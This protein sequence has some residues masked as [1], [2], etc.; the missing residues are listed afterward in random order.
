MFRIYEQTKV[1][2]QKGYFSDPFLIVDDKGVLTIDNKNKQNIALN[3]PYTKTLNSKLTTADA[4]DKMFTD[5]IK[6]L[7]AFFRYDN[8]MLED[9]TVDL[10]SPTMIGGTSWTGFSLSASN[11]HYVET[12]VSTDGTN[13]VSLGEVGNGENRQDEYLNTFKGTLARY[14]RFRAKRNDPYPISVYEGEVYLGQLYKGYRESIHDISSAGVYKGSYA[15]WNQFLPLGTNAWVQTSISLDSGSTWGSWHDLELLGSI[16]GV[17]IGTDLSNAKL[18]VRTYIETTNINTPRFS[19]FNLY[20]DNDHSLDDGYIVIPNQKLTDITIHPIMTSNTTPSPYV[21]TASG[22]V[23]ETNNPIYYAFDGDATNVNTT[24]WRVQGHGSWVKIDLGEDNNKPIAGYEYYRGGIYY[25]IDASLEGSTDDINWVTLSREPNM[26]NITKFSKR[27]DLETNKLPYRYYKLVFN[28]YNTP[29]GDSMY[30]I[31][32]LLAGE[33]YGYQVAGSINVRSNSDIRS[34]MTIRSENN[35][36]LNPTGYTNIDVTPNMSSSKNGNY[37][38][39][40]NF[41]DNVGYEAYKAF[42]G[43]SSKY[44]YIWRE[45]IGAIYT[46]PELQPWITFN[47]GDNNGKIIN[48]Y[49]IFNL[50]T[51]NSNYNSSMPK[52]W[53]LHA[54]NNGYDWKLL[55]ERINEPSW[56]DGQKRSY[57][58]INLNRYTKYRLTFHSGYNPTNFNIAEIEYYENAPHMASQ[59]RSSIIIPQRKDISGSINIRGATFIIFD[60]NYNVEIPKMTADNAPAPYVA[61]ASSVYSY[62][63]PAWK[64]FDKI[65]DVVNDCWISTGKNNEWLQIDYG[66]GNEK[67]VSSYAITHSKFPSNTQNAP[68]KFNLLASND[69]I[70]WYLFDSRE[71]EVGWTAYERRSYKVDKGSITEKFRFY[72][73]HIIEGEADRMLTVNQLELFGP[74]TVYGSQIETKVY[75]KHRSNLTSNINVKG[76]SVII[77][78]DN[79]TDIPAMT[80][81]NTPAPY[82]ISA[83]SFSS[84]NYAW[85]AFNKSTS[86]Y[87][88]TSTGKTSGEWIQIDYGVGNEKYIS[89]YKISAFTNNGVIKSFRLLASNDEVNWIEIDKRTN[90]PSWGTDEVRSY[91]ILGNPAEKFR[92]YR[93]VVLESYF[94]FVNI[95]QLELIGVQEVYGS[96]LYSSLYIKDRIDLSSN[97]YVNLYNRAQGRVNITPVAYSSIPS[98]VVV[99]VTSELVSTI[100]I[101]FYNR[102]QGIVDVI[103]PPRTVVGFNP[104]QDAFVR[105]GAPTFNYGVEQSMLVGYSTVFN[106]LYRSLVQFDISALPKDQIITKAKMKLYNSI[107][108]TDNYR[109][110]AFKNKFDWNET[111]VTWKNHEETFDL[112]TTSSIGQTVGYVEFDIIDIVNEWYLDPSV[113]KGLLLKFIDEHEHENLQFYAR[114]ASISNVRPVLEIEYYNPVNSSFGH[115]NMPSNTFVLYRSDLKSSLKVPFYNIDKSL[116]SNIKIKDKDSIW[117]SLFINQGDV[118]CSVIVTQTDDDDLK[119]NVTVRRSDINEI[120]GSMFVGVP[121]LI[122]SVYVLNREDVPSNIIVIQLDDSEVE[123]SISVSKPDMPSSVFVLHRHDLYSTFVVRG[124]REDEIGGSLSVSN[125]TLHCS[126]SVVFSSSVDSNINVRGNDHI[127]IK[128]KI[129]V[130]HRN[131]LQSKVFVI[132]ASAIEGSINILSGYLKCSL[133]IPYGEFKEIKSSM[134]VRVWWASDMPTTLTIRMPVDD[135]GYAFIM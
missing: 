8:T 15:T 5:G 46:V 37:E 38:V 79:F 130:P 58:F 9:I 84:T 121:D 61:K 122:S 78:K 50:E 132:G 57:E 11:A 22:S 3:K 125:D 94:N 55:D 47:F 40:S 14:V 39:T 68:K 6:A 4:G 98:S 77:I 106:E 123:G 74:T 49:A 118:F 67:F 52:S 16:G 20:F 128:S 86:G 133:S 73:L 18:K 26:G 19:S 97:L 54:S 116:P 25:P 101:P 66:S 45:V 134:N 91:T 35:I 71:N 59:L 115:S 119:S 23:N 126:L 62:S 2:M 90:E 43:S 108:K 65:V 69:E 48:K 103:P 113:N 95:G 81:N 131:D 13:F 114:E 80:S 28:S 89:S 44:N 24:A 53:S 42:D 60:D 83:S 117:G 76:T 36:L 30:E 33:G 96:Q 10:G 127:Q 29:Y 120:D 56:S 31:R 104:I 51:S 93:L 1:Q 34:S 63:Y 102:A 64:A 112:V 41:G 124:Y 110:G 87:W 72:R 7:S 70:N 99:K 100:K 107:A 111:S 32:F 135:E 109:V 92:Y 27:L 75:V 12:F 82:V 17:P 21:L 88:Q 105:E 129:I 85:R